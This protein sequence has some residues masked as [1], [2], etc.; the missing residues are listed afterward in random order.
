MKNKLFVIIIAGIMLVLN[1]ISHAACCGNPCACGPS[2]NCGNPCGPGPCGCGPS[3]NCGSCC[4]GDLGLSPCGS[5]NYW[6]VA[7]SGSVA[8]HNDLRFQGNG[9]SGKVDYKTG[10]GAAASVGYL[11]DLCYGWDWRVEGEFVYRRNKLK[12]ATLIVP[13]SF[14]ETGAVRGH[15]QDA[16]IMANL[17]GGMPLICE[18]RMY[19]G[20]GIGVSFNKLKVNGLGSHVS[21]NHTLFAWQFL[22]GLS[23]C[24][25][26]NVVLTG[27]YRLFGTTKNHLYI[28]GV[29]AHHIPLT[30]SIDFGLRY[31]F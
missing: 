17:I 22:T 24:I 9:V 11:F 14:T 20:G 8:W 23:H 1:Q 16:A 26:P 25:Y 12:N 7:G 21:R 13:D 10:G 30:Q 28:A 19:L 31:G 18:L 3:C 5:I 15:N 6:Y 29:R 27:G 2:C 4:S